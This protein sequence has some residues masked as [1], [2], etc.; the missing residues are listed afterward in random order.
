MLF[1]DHLNRDEYSQDTCGVIIALGNDG[2]NPKGMLHHFRTKHN[3]VEMDAVLFAST[4]I[5][6]TEC[7]SV[8]KVGQYTPKKRIRKPRQVTERSAAAVSPSTSAAVERKSA[9]TGAPMDAVT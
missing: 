9:A 2:A 5:N 8:R 4:K 1:I 7:S 6:E 3:G